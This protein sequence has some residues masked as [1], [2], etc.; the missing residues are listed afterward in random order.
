MDISDWRLEI[1]SIDTELVELLNERA[2]C[3][4]EIGRLKRSKGLPVYSPDR[5]AEILSLVVRRNGG[6]LEPGAIRRLFERIIDESR[7]IER[8][9][10]GGEQ[11]PQAPAAGRSKGLGSPDGDG[12]P[13]PRKRGS[14]LRVTD[15]E[16]KAETGKAW[17]NWFSILDRW[18]A[19]GEEKT[20]LARRLREEHGINP[21]W[22]RAI[23]SQYGKGERSGSRK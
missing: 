22:A 4:I 10:I 1:E 21:R 12:A 14:P 23:V 2:R 13:K 19:K 18:S 17:K 5:E 16:L 9:T 6:P 3:A 11:S 7:R 8:M 20:A 15:A